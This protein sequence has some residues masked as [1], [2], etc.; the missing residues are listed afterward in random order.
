MNFNHFITVLQIQFTR[1]V[2]KISLEQ[3]LHLF[4]GAAMEKF[5][6]QF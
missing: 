6:G 3:N 4:L 5:R 1:P 2:G